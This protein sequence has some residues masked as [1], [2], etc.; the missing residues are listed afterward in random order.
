MNLAII[1]CSYSNYYDGDCFG[2]TYPKLIADNYSNIN[3][4]DASLG[5][6]SNDSCY[7][8]LQNIEKNFGSIDKIIVQLTLPYRTSIALT[9]KAIKDYTQKAFDT[10]E[11]L[12]VAEDKKQALVEFGES[13]VYRTV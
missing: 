10:L 2:N 11:N 1:G 7:L 8:R 9:K 4:Y 12:S 6:A 3:V 13:L 5:G